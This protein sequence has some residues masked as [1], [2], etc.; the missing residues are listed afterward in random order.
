[1]P[2]NRA[3]IDRESKKAEILDAAETL[4]LR[5]GYESTS[6]AAIA[7]AAGV[8]P[9]SIYWYF[10]CKDDLFAAVL[11]R[12]L[13]RGLARLGRD[14]DAPPF[15]GVEAAFAELDAGAKLVAPV[16][17][18][19]KHSPSVAQAHQAFHDAVGRRVAGEFGRL[20]LSKRDARLAAATVIAVVESIHLHEPRDLDARDEL[21]AWLFER[22]SN[23]QEA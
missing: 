10:A 13:E 22:F 19:A 6:M 3:H 9:N 20:G 11:E 2:S 1:M 8:A 17:E 15:A 21:L 16:H 4:L 23:R 5:D 14:T 12:R 7:R 18:R